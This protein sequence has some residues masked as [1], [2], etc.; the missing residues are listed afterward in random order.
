MIRDGEPVTVAIELGELPDGDPTRTSSRED[1]R[2]RSPASNLGIDVMDVTREWSR[3]YESGSGVVIAQ[4][5][6]GSVAEDKN[7]QRGDLIREVNGE[8]VSSVQEFLGIVRQFEAGQAIRFRIQRGDA[9][10]LVG[11]RI[12]E[13]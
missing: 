3:F 12:P 5:R 13:E 10:F 7:L 4:V 2:E 6:S 1:S 9:Q 8:S 11:L